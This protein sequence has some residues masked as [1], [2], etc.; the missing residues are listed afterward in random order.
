MSQG[1]VRSK[2]LLRDG[3]LEAV[4]EVVLRGNPEGHLR[5]STPGLGEISGN[6]YHD[7]AVPK[8]LEGSGVSQESP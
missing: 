2:Y 1:Q 8:Q 4:V 5:T 7:G 3:V 6:Q